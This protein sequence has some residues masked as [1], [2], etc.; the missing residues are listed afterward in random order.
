MSEDHEDHRH[1]PA[2]SAPGAQDATL[3]R[4]LEYHRRVGDSVPS[5]KRHIWPLLAQPPQLTACARW[6]RE[7]SPGARICFEKRAGRVLR[8]A[9]YETLDGGAS[10][11][12]STELRF[13]VAR[14]YAAIRRC[15]RRG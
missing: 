11:A 12:Y 3:E 4:M 2:A 1:R 7:M 10:G 5:E 8:E 13:L 6:K 9:G 14:L 15:L